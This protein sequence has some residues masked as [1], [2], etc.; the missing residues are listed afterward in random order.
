[1]ATRIDDLRHPGC[2]P[3]SYNPAMRSW[4]VIFLWVLAPLQLS[5][6]AADTRVAQDSTHTIASHGAHPHASAQ[7]QSTDASAA[8]ADCST[9]HTSCAMACPV[10]ARQAVAGTTV[11]PTVGTALLPASHHARRPDRPQWFARA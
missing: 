10:E 1:M 2:W 6:A 5:W 11:L 4:L 8:P 3:G 9:C 7:P